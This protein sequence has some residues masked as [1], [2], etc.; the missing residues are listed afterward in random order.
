MQ[1]RVTIYPSNEAY[2]FLATCIKFK[3]YLFASEKNIIYC[4]TADAFA[5]HLEIKDQIK[6]FEFSQKGHIIF[7]RTADEILIY[8]FNRTLLRKVRFGVGNFVFDEKRNRIITFDGNRISNFNNVLNNVDL[9]IKEMGD[10]KFEKIKIETKRVREQSVLIE[11][12]K[13]SKFVDD[14]TNRI[15]EYLGER[16]RKRLNEL[17]KPVDELLTRIDKDS[18]YDSGF[19]LENIDKDDI[20]R[21]K[22]VLEASQESHRKSND[23]KPRKKAKKNRKKARNPFIDECAE[24][25]DDFESEVSIEEAEERKHGDDLGLF[26]VSKEEDEYESE[27]KYQKSSDESNSYEENEYNDNKTFMPGSFT[28]N[29][30]SLFC[31]NKT[32]FIINYKGYIEAIF[33][34]SEISQRDFHCQFHIGTVHSHGIVFADKDM[35]YFYGEIDWQKPIKDTKLLGITNSY[36]AAVT[37]KELFSF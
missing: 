12:E 14:G 22:E 23:R 16:K 20:Y 32:G 30:T 17:S 1:G 3:K 15:A 26:E 2:D 8:D 27:E 19:N 34:D 36:V 24:E 5:S 28:L 25:K 29:D 33:H 11:H 37:N 21:D 31:Y 9:L 18:M 35:V 7:V 10:I 4:K 13:T 6:E